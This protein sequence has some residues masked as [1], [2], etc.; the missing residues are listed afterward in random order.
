MAWDT[1][2]EE[3][4]EVEVEGSDGGVFVLKG[5]NKGK[6]AEAVWSKVRTRRIPR[7]SWTGPAISARTD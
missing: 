1:L 5:Q 7:S 4:E 6:Q 2:E 3:E